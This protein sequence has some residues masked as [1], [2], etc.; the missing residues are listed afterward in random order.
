MENRVPS[1]KPFKTLHQRIRS[2]TP[3]V[4]SWT[5]SFL[6]SPASNAPRKTMSPKTSSELIALVDEYM[7]LPDRVQSSYIDVSPP[8][9][10]P[11]VNS[12]LLKLPWTLSN[13]KPTASR[14]LY[15]E[16]FGNGPRRL[17]LI[18]GMMGSTMYWR[19][20]TKYFSRLGDYTV[21]VFDN[22]GSG[23]S[24]LAPGPYKIS[25]MAQDALLVL[26]HL[27]WQKDVHVVGISMGG[28]IA[29]EMCLASPSGRFASVVLVD[30]WHSAALA[31]PTAKEVKFAFSGMSA[32]SMSS[33][34]G[35]LVDL[36]FSSKWAND[37]FHDTAKS[38]ITKP[39]MDPAAVV[40]SAD[41]PTNKQVTTALFDAVQIELNQAKDEVKATLRRSK[42]YSR[43]PAKSLTAPTASN[44]RDTSADIHQFMASLG[45]RLSTNKV[46]EIR[47]K[48]PQTRFLVIHGDSDRVIRPMC[49]RSLAKLLQCPIVWMKGAGHMPP[50]DAHCSFNLVVRAF[51]RQ[52][53]WWKLL[54]DKSQINPPS[55][56]EQK[57]VRSWILEK[58]HKR[59]HMRRNITLDI[60]APSD[61]TIKESRRVSLSYSDSETTTTT[62]TT[63]TATRRGRRR[64]RIETIESTGPLQQELLLIDEEDPL[65]PGRI[66]PPVLPTEQSE[67][68]S[69]RQLVIHGVL[70]DVP[71]RVRKYDK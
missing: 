66:I 4:V 35:M 15:F 47:N 9:S 1:V 18:M 63:A 12:G 70:M 8:N 43:I 57:R 49:G 22:C 38:G 56:Q 6:Q 67:P 51:T 10:P 58:Q 59:P 48:H 11:T 27:G 30:T 62:T 14:K 17:F 3:S 60:A 28:M 45:H 7:S 16:T 65:R 29:Q 37:T 24:A 33:G 5:P 54:T 42:S 50:I 69:D 71:I 68:D 13:K 20:Q 19:L 36:V 26:D 2:T 40:G 25:K 39:M 41:K 31:L 46:R 44:K 52:E 64:S 53:A 61:E 21:C 32:I 55:W 23:R 34:P